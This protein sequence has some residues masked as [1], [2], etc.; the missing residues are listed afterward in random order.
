MPENKKLIAKNTLYL[1]VRMLLVMCVALYTSRV[2]LSSLGA[3]DYGIYNV[4]GGIVIMFSFL[5]GSLSGATSRYMSYDLGRNDFAQL[6][7]TFSASLNIYIATAILIM[8]LGEILG[9]WLLCNKLTIPSDRMNAA[10]WVLQFTIITAFFNFTQYPYTASLIAHENMSVYAYAGI[11]EAVS[12]LIIALAIMISPI[13]HLIFYALLLMINQIGVLLFYRYYAFRKYEECRFQLIKDKDLYK[14]LLSYSGYDMLP[15]MGFIVQEQG[16]NIMLNVFFGPVVN[17]AKAISTQVN[18]AL[19]QFVINILQAARPQVIMQYAQGN[20]KEMYSLTFLVAK[21]SYLL[22]LAMIMPLWVEMDYVINL[23]L[24]DVAP[25]KSSLFCKIVLLNVMV[26]ALSSS[27]AM[28]MHAIGK[29][30]Y[31]SIIN[32]ILFLLPL[33]IGYVFFRFGLPDYSI[34]LLSVIFNILIAVNVLIQLYHLKKYNL[35]YVFKDICIVCTVITILTY[36]VLSLEHIYLTEGFLRLVAVVLTSSIMIS[37]Y[38]W[39][40]VLSNSQRKHIKTLILNKL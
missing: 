32:S 15:S 21:F 39:L 29:L 31:Y 36:M 27:I 5:S 28:S 25:P 11:Y 20:T 10:H 16:I 7:K 4:V 33:P 14:K 22:M 38:S 24:G 30:R 37:C 40:Y 13:D 8:I 18:G 6:R 1:Y 23:W 9:L 34:L 26:N 19:N 17:A 3:T 35:S 12:R 2:I